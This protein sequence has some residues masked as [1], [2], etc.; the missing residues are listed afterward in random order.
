MT[1]LKK[2]SRTHLAP[3]LAVLLALVVHRLSR[4]REGYW[5]QSTRHLGVARVIAAVSIL[6]W[7]GV[8]M[9]GRWIAY[10]DYLFWPE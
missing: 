6:L 5:Q 10:S 3:R 8:V 1:L 9:A 7:V 4:R 2:P